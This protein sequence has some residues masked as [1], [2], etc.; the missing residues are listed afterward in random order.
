[1]MRRSVYRQ[2]VNEGL[3]ALTGDKVDAPVRFA[4]ARSAHP[5]ATYVIARSG[6]TKQPRSMQRWTVR[7]PK[8]RSGPAS[9]SGDT[10]V[11][12]EPLPDLPRRSCMWRRRQHRRC[13][14]MRDR[15]GNRR[16]GI[17]LR[18]LLNRDRR[19]P[20]GEQLDQL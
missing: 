13:N 18:G 4:E 10:G 17:I 16:I 14:D 8:R 2:E 12:P 3:L 20:P 5:H 7:A 9:A 15:T 19:L 11:Q 1:M 6:A